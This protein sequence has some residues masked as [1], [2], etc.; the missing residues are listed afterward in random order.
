MECLYHVL[1]GLRYDQRNPSLMLIPVFWSRPVL[2]CSSSFLTGDLIWHLQKPQDISFYPAPTTV[3]PETQ[4]RASSKL[5]FFFLGTP[6]WS[7][8]AFQCKDTPLPCHS[9][10]GSLYSQSCGPLDS[11]SEFPWSPPEFS[12]LRLHGREEGCG[13]PFPPSVICQNT[14]KM[15]CS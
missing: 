10:L 12:L 13:L 14:G 7:C 11:N 2:E 3:F 9:S 15:A 4:G 8:L 1:E 5:T 6:P